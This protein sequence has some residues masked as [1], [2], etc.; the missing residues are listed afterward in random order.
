MTLTLGLI[1]TFIIIHGHLSGFVISS[2]LAFH[3]GPSTNC[4]S[5]CFLLIYMYF[6][7]PIY[8]WEL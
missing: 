2:F 6:L 8:I 1:R 7:L 5:M 3:V 4:Y